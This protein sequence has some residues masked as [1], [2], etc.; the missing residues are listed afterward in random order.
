LLG[1]FRRKTNND[2]KPLSPALLIAK[3]RHEI[4]RLGG[5]R[6]RGSSAAIGSGAGKAMSSVSKSQPRGNLQKVL[7]HRKA[8]K[9]ILHSATWQGFNN[10]FSDIFAKGTAR[11][12]GQ[13]NAKHQ[14]S[15]GLKVWRAD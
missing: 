10:Y 12:S 15:R 2:N 1:C 6:T 11:I 3:V 9:E 7:G 13:K 4:S 8:D 14:R 5:K